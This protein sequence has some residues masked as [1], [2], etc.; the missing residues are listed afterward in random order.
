MKQFIK[1]ILLFSSVI[2]VLGGI[3]EY[4]LRQPN[5]MYKFK[6]EL[7][8]TKADQIET[9]IIGSSVVNH[10]L[11]PKYMA[12]GTYNM[13]VSGEWMR[14]NK[15][16]LERYINRLNGLKYI[17]WG[18]CYHGLWMDDTADFSE[19]SVVNHKLY[20]NIQAENDWGHNSELI[21]LR[22]IA[23]RKWSK[24]YL[25]H[26]ETMECDSLG[27]DH[28]FDTKHI[29][30]S[31]KEDIP[32]LVLKHINYMRNDQSNLYQQNLN[33]I[34]EVATLC[35]HKGIHLFL[36]IPPVYNEFKELADP[37]Q[38]NLIETGFHTIVN[39][40][41]HVHYLNYFA[42]ERFNQEDFYD[43]NHLNSDVGAVKFAKILNKDIE[44]IKTTF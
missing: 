18:Q 20:M 43:G 37:H 39:E 26:Q 4:M 27:L 2:I 40:F 1:Y 36:V 25:K 32:A 9:M 33:R 14:F 38:L 8:E 28:H 24:Y 30:P 12:P 3:M 5:N 29:N 19:K 10:G 17:I 21:S 15:I 44:T 23:F 7:I 34:R 41:S 13:A 22:A 6:K 31:W 11:D 42:D 16:L 35:K